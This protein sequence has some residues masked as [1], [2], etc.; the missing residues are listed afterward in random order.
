MSGRP[1]LTAGEAARRLS[2]IG[3]NEI[4]RQPPPSRLAV[5]AGQFGSPLVWLLLGA[6]LVSGLLGEIADAIAIGVIVVVNAVVGYVQEWRAEGALLALRAMTAPRA[7]VRRD[8]QQAVVAATEVVPGDLLLLEA[9]DVVAA[10]ASLLEANVLTTNESALTGESLPAS[11]RVD[12]T[13]PDAPMAERHDQVFMGTTVAAGTGSAEV[14][15]T[16]TRTE[17]GRVA[18]LMETAEQT[19]TPLQQ[20][21]VRVGRA[22][23]FLCLGLVAVT[24]GIGLLRGQPAFEVFLSAV[25]L[26]V[27]AVPEG[28]PAV[29]TIALAV[30]VQRMAARQVLIRRLPAVETLG[31]ASVICTDKTG[32]LTTGVMTVRDSWGDPG[33]VL[34]AAAACCDAELGPDGRGGVGDSTELAILA[35]AA[36]RGIF[37]DAIEHDRPRRATHPFDAERRLMSVRRADGTLYVKGAFESVRPLASNV[38][39]PAVRA[40]AEM[41]ERGL[42]VLAVALGDGEEER[43]LRLVGLIGL[44]DPPRS[45]AI[46]AVATARSAGLRTVMITGDHPATARAIAVEMGI[47]GPGESADELVF[48]RATPEDK[49][50]LVRA[51]KQRGAIVAMTGDGVNDAPALREAHI[52]VAMGQAGTEVAREA[53]DV[54]LADDNYASIVAAVRE[55]RGIFDNIRKTLVYLLAGNT[56]ELLLMLA[57]S[58]V[59]LPLPLLPLHLLWINLVTDGLPALALVMDP[60]TEDVMARPPRPADEPMLGRAQWID[61]GLTGIL[62]GS[63]VLATF[64]FVLRTR[65]LATARSFAFTTLVFGELFRSFATRNPTRLLPEIG[66]FSNWRLVAVVLGSAVVQIVIHEIPRM[67]VLVSDPALEHARGR[68]LPGPGPHPGHRRRAIE[69]RAPR[70]PTSSHALSCRA[71]ARWNARCSSFE[72]HDAVGAGPPHCPCIARGGAFER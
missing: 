61:I 47:V 50:H 16:G 43:D 22:L 72:G 4:P 27:A 25:S 30:G 18:R 55:G 40:N 34:R 33:E 6:C 68:R 58:A 65:D 15:A 51:W 42:R 57:A 39:D 31:S 35:A 12:R 26:A 7:R 20:R 67:E 49:L 24:A 38:G 48:A 71:A 9:G 53:A 11:K 17:L 56:G 41:A 44:A 59:G 69:A 10:D 54:V 3:P 5:L 60:P 52:G 36:E 21:L 45:E 19:E 63:V 2:E 66:V 28:L 23:L 13:A 8:G 14:K 32:T 46:E 37:R 29:V 70:L 62:Q 64:A 1:G